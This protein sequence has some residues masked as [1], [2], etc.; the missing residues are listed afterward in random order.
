MRIL[1]IEDS[2]PLQRSIKTGLKKNGFKVDVTGD[3]HEGLW[4][5]ESYEYDAIILD[6]M[7]P[8]LDG[9]SILKKLRDQNI[10][11]HVLILSARDNR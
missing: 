4:H 10:P 7:L 5:A 11:V 9:L 3:G 6:L 2:K 1:L 8:G